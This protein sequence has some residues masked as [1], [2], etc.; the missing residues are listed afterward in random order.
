LGGR[1]HSAING[2]KTEGGR[3]GEDYWIVKTDATGNKQWDKR[4]GG[5][6]D[7]KLESIQQTTDDGFILGNY[8]LSG[9]GGDKTEYSR[10]ASDYWIVKTD[11]TGNK[12]WDKRFGGAILEYY[13]SVEQTKDGGYILGGYSY[14]G[15]GGDKTEDNRG[16]VDYW[17]VKLGCPPLSV[18]TASGSLDIC[19]TGSVQLSVSSADGLKYRWIKNNRIIPAA[20]YNT[21]TAI[22]PGTYRVVVY[23][24]I[25]CAGLSNPLTVINSCGDIAANDI[26]ISPNPSKGLINV[27][28]NSI[29]SAQIT[30]IIYDKAGRILFTKTEQA[31]AGNNVYR[32]NLSNLLP[33]TYN[34][35]LSNNS[36]NRNIK[37]IIQ[38]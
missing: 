7:D 13:G 29:T 36:E 26:A 22:E 2:D 19:Q 32:L 4:F 8:S 14:S 18:I 15:T 35:Q 27:T 16:L 11:A 9:M 5:I 33:G 17:I 23:T 24:G 10:G 38:K 28:Y 37:F 20:K 21:Y 6:G 30:L 1:S 25:K 31:L 12:Q 34:L 3:G